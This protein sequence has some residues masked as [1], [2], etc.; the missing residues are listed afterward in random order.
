M[1][2]KILEHSI[3]KTAVSVYDDNITNSRY[4]VANV[5]YDHLAS[6]KKWREN[7]DKECNMIKNIERKLIKEIA[8]VGKAKSDFETTILESSVMTDSGVKLSQQAYME[9]RNAIR[10]RT[11]DEIKYA[12]ALIE[13]GI[14]NG[15][16]GINNKNGKLIACERRKEIT[17]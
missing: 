4:S 6:G 5:N 14:R 2:K 9:R 12:F 7:S 1:N 10:K 3:R 17:Q 11:P 15:R 8:Y 16:I 13:G